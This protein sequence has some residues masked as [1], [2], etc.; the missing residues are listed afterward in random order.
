LSAQASE[1][2]PSSGFDPHK[3]EEISGAYPSAV[4]A[5]RTLNSVL[6]RRD[7]AAFLERLAEAVRSGCGVSE[8]AKNIRSNRVSVY[9]ML[10]RSGNPG[11]KA[12]MGILD[13]AGLRIVIEPK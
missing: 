13:A 9:R 5:A 6:S 3:N 10:S 8:A 12:V 7:P 2:N 1:K 11:F 4:S